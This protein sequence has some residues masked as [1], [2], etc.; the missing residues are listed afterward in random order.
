VREFLENV[1]QVHLKAPPPVSQNV[2]AGPKAFID[3]CELL[4]TCVHG[5]VLWL[6]FRVCA[7]GVGW[8]WGQGGGRQSVRLLSWDM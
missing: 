8:T 2:I 4:S 6:W 3:Q 5:A 1:E 7:G